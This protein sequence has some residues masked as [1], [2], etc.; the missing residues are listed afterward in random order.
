VTIHAL[1]VAVGA[2]EDELVGEVVEVAVLLELLELPLLHAAAPVAVSA[3]IATTASARL[4]RMWTPEKLAGTLESFRYFRR[5]AIVDSGS[6]SVNP[7]L[8]PC[9]ERFHMTGFAV[10]CSMNGAISAVQPIDR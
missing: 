5:V 2:L 8:S 7:Q 6:R 3:A 4:L 9:Y 1:T 10:P